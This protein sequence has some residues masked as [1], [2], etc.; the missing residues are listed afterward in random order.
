MEWFK[1]LEK[2]GTGIWWAIHSVNGDNFY[3]AA[4]LNNLSTVHK[5]AEIGFWILPA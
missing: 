2:Q 3:G 1:N 4:G 5:K